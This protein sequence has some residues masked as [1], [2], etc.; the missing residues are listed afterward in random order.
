MISVGSTLL[1]WSE[2]DNASEGVLDA[3][4]PFAATVNFMNA[5]GTVALTRVTHEGNAR[6][7]PSVRLCDQTAWDR[8]GSSNFA[9]RM[10]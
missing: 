3:A 9:T 5:D 8:H 7:M 2:S 1:F 4:Q 6:F 10:P